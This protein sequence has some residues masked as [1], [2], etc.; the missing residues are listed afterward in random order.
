MAN[1][2]PQMPKRRNPVKKNMDKFHR[3]QTYRDRTKYRRQEDD[4]QSQL[5][6]YLDDENDEFEQEREDKQKKEFKVRLKG[7]E[8]DP[9]LRK[10]WEDYIWRQN[11]PDGY[12]DHP[13]PEDDFLDDY[14]FDDN[15]DY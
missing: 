14:Y 5:D 6:D 1:R 3:P 12:F 9:D 7:E 13:F 15:Y 4:W 11:F 8:Y 2:R 10:E